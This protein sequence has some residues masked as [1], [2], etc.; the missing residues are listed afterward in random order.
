[1]KAW[2][3][4]K[5]SDLS[6]CTDPLHLQDLKIPEPGPHDVLVRVTAC[7][8]CHTELDEIEGRLPCRLPVVPGHQAVGTV[9]QTGSRATLL[10]EGDRVGIAWIF[11]SCGH[12]SYCTSGKENLCPEYQGTGKDVNGGYAEYM[13]VPEGYVYPIPGVLSD[14][15][16]A[17][18]LC[19]GSIGYRSL[20]LTGMR[21]GDSLGLTGFGGSGHLVLKMARYLYPESK[22][23]VFARNP[24]ERIFALEL[25]AFWAGDINE[26]PP[27]PLHAIIDTTPVW[28]P[29]ISSLANLRPAGRLVINAIRKEQIDQDSLL[30][31]DYATHIWQEKEI[32]S[33][34]NVCREDVKAFLELSAAAGIKPHVEIYPF[35]EANRALLDLKHRRIRGAKVLQIL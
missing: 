9:E 4:E 27:A 31:L 26:S 22:V 13:V 17:P 25:G 2:V 23:L 14:V 1:M 16:V 7:G 3:L 32:K 10:R 18:L 34:A 5:N 35:A 29:V 21:N 30:G 6:T 33:V 28:Q 15:D 20:H 24:E 12:C 19:A 11:S 8:V